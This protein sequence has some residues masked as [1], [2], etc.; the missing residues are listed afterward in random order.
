MEKFNESSCAINYYYV[1]NFKNSLIPAVN[2]LARLS[3]NGRFISRQSMSNRPAS[4]MN[5]KTNPTSDGVIFHA[6]R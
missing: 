2:N 3:R 4:R 6:E 1:D 5:M